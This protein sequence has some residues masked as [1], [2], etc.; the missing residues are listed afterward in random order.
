M[1]PRKFKQV[2]WDYYAKYGRDLAW[3]KTTDPYRIVVSEVMLQQTQVDR[4]K[5]YYERFIKQFPTFRA[6]AKAPTAEVLKA[7]QG[8]GYNR[9]ALNLQKLAREVVTKYKG[10]LPA[11]PVLLDE[12]P[13][14]GT[15]TAG[16]IAAFAFDKPTPFIETNIRRVFIHAFF[17]QKSQVH[18]DDILKLVEKTLDLKRAREW[19]YAL[20]DYGSHLAKK[21]AN[22]NRQSKHYSKQS[23]FEGSNR[24]LRGRILKGLLATPALSKKEMEQL[25]GSKTKLAHV[26]SE[27]RRE[28]FIR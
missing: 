12:L 26:L 21:V 1:T 9:R 18:D 10:K 13:G 15:G 5:P 4:V 14:I 24:Q 7:W 23:K 22:P 6:L 17:A 20:M 16:S 2:I 25:A 11:D 8:L 3:R 27:L 19:Y 28:G